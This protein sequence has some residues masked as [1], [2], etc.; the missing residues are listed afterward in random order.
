MENEFENYKEKIAS[1]YA[2]QY[3][4]PQFGDGAVK[5]GLLE[6]LV[7]TM[8]NFSI[9]ERTETADTESKDIS[10]KVVNSKKFLNSKQ[11]AN[12][13]YFGKEINLNELYKLEYEK[14][15]EGSAKRIRD[16]FRYAEIN[17]EFDIINK[18]VSAMKNGLVWN[19]HDGKRLYSEFFSNYRQFGKKSRGL[20]LDYLESKEFDFSKDY[21]ERAVNSFNELKSDLDKPISTLKSW[22]GSKTMNA[23]KANGIEYCGELAQKSKAELKKMNGIGKVAMLEIGNRADDRLIPMGANINYKRPENK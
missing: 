3:L 15:I 18:M 5:A 21:A 6:G 8:D 16:I 22:L 14:G 13:S 9:T 7:Q 2:K 19:K 23:L 10:E 1:E 4:I 17:S 11:S 20:I 12:I